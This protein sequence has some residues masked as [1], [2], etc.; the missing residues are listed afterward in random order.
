MTRRGS[1]PGERR[2]GR[3]PGVCNK[4]TAEVKVLAQR[5]GPAAI[6]EAVRLMLE[7]KSE[8]ARLAAISLILD[9][10]YGK[11]TQPHAL[12][13]VGDQTVIIRLNKEDLA[14]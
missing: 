14:L 9:R 6:E 13:D 11:A 10:G 2:G 5:H 4:A 12:G 3:K 8:T 1:A 7:A